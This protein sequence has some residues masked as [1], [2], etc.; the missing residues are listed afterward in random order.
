[1]HLI[2]FRRRHEQS[3]K[4]WI[5]SMACIG[6]LWWVKASVLRCRTK[7]KICFTYFLRATLELFCGNAL[8]ALEIKNVNKTNE[9][10]FSNSHVNTAHVAVTKSS[11]QTITVNIL[12]FVQILLHFKMKQINAYFFLWLLLSHTLQRSVI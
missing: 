1:M 7:P 2:R 6:M 5:K 11:Y 3:K 12:K 10:I 4:R 9:S 8:R